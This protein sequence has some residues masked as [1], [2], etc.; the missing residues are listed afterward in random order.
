LCAAGGLELDGRDEGLDERILSRLD[1]RVHSLEQALAAA[2]MASF[3]RAFFEALHPYVAM[4]RDILD[5][6]EHADATRGESQWTLQV[7]DID[8]SLEHF[9][10]WLAKWDGLAKAAVTVPAIDEKAV[11]QLWS[12]LQERQAVRDELENSFQHKQLN[13]SN[14]ARQWVSSYEQGNY[15]PLP[16]SLSPSQCP[17]ALAKSATIAFAVL[18]RLFDQGL[19]PALLK[20]LY[21]QHRRDVHT[22]GG[23]NIYDPSDGFDIWTIAQHETDFWLQSF[24]VVLSAASRLPESE[25]TTIGKDLDAITDRFPMRAVQVDVA[26][27]DLESL[28]SLP[29][30]E[31]RFDLYSAWIATE[32]IRA[33]KGHDVE[34]H[35]DQGRLAFAFKETTLATIRSSPDAF[36]L[37]S[38]RRIPLANPRGEGRK[39]GVQPD[40]GLWTT[41]D[42]SEVCKMV[43]EVK[44]YKNSSKAKFVAVFEDYARALPDGDIYLVNHGPVGAAVSDV[45]RTLRDRCK[46]IGH[47]TSSNSESRG[48]LASAVRKCVG[49]PMPRWPAPTQPLNLSKALL[50]DVSGSMSATMRSRRNAFVCSFAGREGTAREARGCRS[51]DRRCLGHRRGWF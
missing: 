50:I 5:F 19:T 32:I 7:D 20:G 44:H 21:D 43:I 9:R 31:K 46:A 13:I 14:D 1:A 47:L 22:R 6:F 30:W 39:G 49:E 24:V 34:I 37:I 27:G 4:F 41:N 29:L 25:L 12:V 8:L 35:H 48:E 40:H 38:E 15:L 23:H 17:P 3:V 16:K 11:W 42:G 10:K 33:L 18:Q 45:S 28:L 36:K 51:K 2:D 26:I